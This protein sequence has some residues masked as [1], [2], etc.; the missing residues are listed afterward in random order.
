MLNH[1]TFQGRMTRNPE[2][3]RT[4]SGKAV[5]SFTLAVDDDYK[6]ADGEK[7]TAFVDCV[8]WGTLAETVAKY[9]AKGQMAIA[10]GRLTFRDWTDRDGQKRRSTEIVASN[11]YFCEKKENGAESQQTAYSQPQFSQPTYQPETQFTSLDGDDD[12]LPF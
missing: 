5:T 9:F 1:C 2:L 10:V 8:A 3:R 4:Q 7:T 6:A 11:V 12:Q